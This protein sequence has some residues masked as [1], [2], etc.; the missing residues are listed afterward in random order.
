[1]SVCAVFVGIR[2]APLGFRGQAAWATLWPLGAA[3]LTAMLEL[4]LLLGTPVGFALAARQHGSIQTSQS[5]SSSASVNRWRGSIGILAVWL[6]LTTALG[7]FANLRF[8]APGRVA[9]GVVR[10]A[11]AV[12]E[13]SARR[14]VEPV[15]LI[16]ARWICAPATQS[17]IEG[18]I[19]RRGA[20]A[21][22]SA[23]DLTVSEELDYVDLA[24]LEIFSS[25]AQGRPAVHLV[26]NGARVRGA[27][28]WAK[29]KRMPAV[30]RAFYVA[31]LSAT[32]GLLSILL[33]RRARPGSRW[34]AVVPGVAGGA[35][36]WSV[37][38]VVDA[39]AT[40]HKVAYA[41]VPVAA[42]VAMLAVGYLLGHLSLTG[43]IVSFL[44]RHWPWPHSLQ[45]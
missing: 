17:R 38:D 39:H 40:W 21:R 4:A 16:G 33:T 5:A 12:C 37:L 29:A 19:S 34:N 15:P 10:G 7:A 22:Y 24:A 31:S 26:A 14:R 41:A 8:G 43:Y 36:A 1:M 30:W 11:R 42:A 28:P 2:L 32:L 27:W 3:A 18:E 45:R 44:R 20:T 6:A 25:A 35:T 23:S 9:G 13:E